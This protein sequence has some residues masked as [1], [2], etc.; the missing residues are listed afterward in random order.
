MKNAVIAMSGGVD[1]SVAAFLMKEKGYDLRGVTLSLYTENDRDI[2]DAKNICNNLGFPHET[3]NMKQEFCDTVIADFINA[4]ENS[5]TP[6]PCIVCNKKI[7]FGKLLDY[8]TDEGFAAIVTGHYARID[9]MGDRYIL[10]KGKDQKKDQT[11][12]LYSL[13]QHQ[14]SHTVLPLGELS[15]SEVREIADSNNLVTAR[16]SD[17]Q[18]ICFIPEGKYA[19]FIED[20]L[21]KTYPEGDFVD[22]DGNVWGTHKGLIRYTIGQRKGLGLALPKPMYVCNLC[23]E[24]NTV[25]L[26]DN[27]D[28]FKSDLTASKINFITCDTLRSPIKCEAKV[29]YSQSAQ[30]A[31]VWQTAEDEIRVEFDAPQRAIT[32]GQAVVLYDGD[33]VI[34]GGTIN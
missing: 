3:L 22:I 7:K 19:E 4:Y 34:G 10:K 32:P 31:T 5:R 18:D 9:K 24:N 28:L 14:L 15:K 1:S 27:A 11:Y 20:Y 21:G 23:P 12:M 2:A 30:P 26:G 16:K 6:N 17:S 25:I 8:A 13:T 33:T 29:R